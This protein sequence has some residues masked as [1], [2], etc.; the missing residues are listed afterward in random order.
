MTKQLGMITIGQAP[1]TDV[2]PVLEKYLEGRAELL[3]VGVLDGLSAT[4]I[5]ALAPES[6]EY[7]LTSRLQDGSA[8][9]VS[10]EKIRP[11]LNQKIREFEAMG[12]S[13]ILLLCTGSFPGLR[14]AKVHLIEP[15]RIIPPAVQAMA[16]GRRLGLIGPLAEQAG[17]LDLKF[18]SLVQPAFAA[19][20]PYTSGEDEFRQATE[21]LKGRVELILLDCMGY[22]ERHRQWVA[23]AS[24]GIPVILSNALMGQLVAEMV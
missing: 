11:M 5:A 17:Q 3:Q 4:Q 22:D 20:S 9:I 12:V 18:S 7:V 8:A 23:N 1:R 6:G 21:S 10:R 24:A 2:A 14:S 15:D 19:A 16:D 13:N